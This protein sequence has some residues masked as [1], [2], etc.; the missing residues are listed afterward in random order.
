MWAGGRSLLIAVTFPSNIFQAQVLKRACVRSQSLALVCLIGRIAIC[1][2]GYKIFI[3]FLRSL[4]WG[5]CFFYIINS[6]VLWSMI[7]NL[8]AKILLDILICRGIFPLLIFREK[9]KISVFNGR[10]RQFRWTSHQSCIITGQTS[11][12]THIHVCFECAFK[13]QRADWSSFADLKLKITV[14]RSS[15]IDLRK[16]L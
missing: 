11:A 12:H 5:C 6:L 10:S 14:L 16:F 9:Q 13:S 4:F 3:F 15:H 2:F 7:F 8:G 1:A